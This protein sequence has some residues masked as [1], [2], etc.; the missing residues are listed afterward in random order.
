MFRAS[1]FFLHS[2]NP[3]KG[4]GFRAKIAS[5]FRVPIQKRNEALEEEEWSS[6][7]R[8]VGLWMWYTQKEAQKW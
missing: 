5:S 8:K 4:L 2:P 6:E 3:R 7:G 1:F